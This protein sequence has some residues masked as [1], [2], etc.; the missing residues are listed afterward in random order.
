MSEKSAAKEARTHGYARTKRNQR[1]GG[2]VV[3]VVHK[4]TEQDK[5]VARLAKAVLA[6]KMEADEAIALARLIDDAGIAA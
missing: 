2:R 6:G 4:P 5:M 3:G 1:V